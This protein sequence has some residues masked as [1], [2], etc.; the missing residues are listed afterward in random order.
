MKRRVSLNTVEPSE[1]NGRCGI[2]FNKPATKVFYIEN[3]Y[4]L[5]FCD[6]CFEKVR[7]M[8]MDFDSTPCIESIHMI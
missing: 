7:R 2:C 5:R 6:K 8:F 3:L 4:E 1:E